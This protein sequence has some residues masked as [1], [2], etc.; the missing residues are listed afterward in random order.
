MAPRPDT[1]VAL[2]TP[3]GRG[4]LAVVRLSGPRTAELFRTVAPAWRGPA[5][6]REPLLVALADGRRSLPLDRALATFFPEP[7]SYTGEEM[8]E[9]STHGGSLVPALLIE[10]LERAGARPAAPGEFTKRAYLNGKLDLVQAEGIGDLVEARSE[11]SHRA[12]VHQM[13]GGLSRTVAALRDRLL[14]LEVLLAY[15]VDFP[16]EDDPPVPVERIVAEGEALAGDLRRLLQRAPEGEMLR[17]GALA[18]LAGRPNSGKSSLFNALLG[19]ERSIV[20]DEPGTTRDAIEAGCSMEGYPFRL[21]D[22]AG[23]REGGGRVERLGIEVARRYLASAEVVLLCLPLQGMWGEEEAFLAGLDEGTPVV[24]LR[25]KADEGGGADGARPDLPAASPRAERRIHRAIR[26]SVR[27]GRGL[28]ELR[29]CLARLV[30]R[31]FVAVGGVVEPVLT[32]RRQASAV[33]RAL[34]EVEA[35]TRSLEGGVPAEFAATHLRCAETALEELLGVLS[36][37]DVLDRVFAEYC[38]GK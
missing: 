25:T 12:A 4:A 14:A 19:V 10:A 6:P 28:G 9:I 26:V 23:I 31:G 16:E 29:R 20:T 37:E 13:E 18:V 15:H 21:V 2:A 38:V 3:P 7:R 33:R 30:F 22:T 27:D 17:E 32:R 5:R 11:A 34:N 24:L 35:F 8:V 1:I 36:P